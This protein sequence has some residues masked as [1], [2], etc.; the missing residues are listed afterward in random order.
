MSKSMRIQVR[1]PGDVWQRIIAA[2]SL[3]GVPP[4]L[5]VVEACNARLSS[6]PECPESP[7]VAPGRAIIPEPVRDYSNWDCDGPG[8]TD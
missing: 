6:Y 5:W 1:F 4:T 3:D 7:Q 8:W 2:S